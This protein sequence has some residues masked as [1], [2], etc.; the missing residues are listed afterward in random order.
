[1]KNA[2]WESKRCANITIFLKKVCSKIKYL[3]EVLKKRILPFLHFISAKEIEGC[4]SKTMKCFFM[5]Y[6]INRMFLEKFKIL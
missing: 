5:S 6:H 2:H 1:M 4:S 3:K